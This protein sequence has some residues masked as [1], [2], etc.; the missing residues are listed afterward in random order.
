MEFPEK[1]RGSKFGMKCNRFFLPIDLHDLRELCVPAGLFRKLKFSGQDSGKPRERSVFFFETDFSNF[2]LSE[3]G[4]R[5][6]LNKIRGNLA[7]SA[8]IYDFNLP[9]GRKKRF[10]AGTLFFPK[11]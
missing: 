2:G 8:A 1:G 6:G 4:L 9:N 10:L 5:G 3:I 7:S 11:S